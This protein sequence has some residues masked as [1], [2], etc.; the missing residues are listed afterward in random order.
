MGFGRRLSVL[1][2]WSFAFTA[3]RRPER[4]TTPRQAQWPADPLPSVT[5]LETIDQERTSA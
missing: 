2:R 3:D 4:V 5:A 1:L